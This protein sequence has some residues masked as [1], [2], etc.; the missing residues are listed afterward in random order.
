M[1]RRRLGDSLGSTTVLRPRHSSCL[2]H[3]CCLGDQ[4]PWGQHPSKHELGHPNYRLTPILSPIFQGSSLCLGSTCLC[5]QKPVSIC[6]SFSL[7]Q[8]SGWP[9][10][11]HAAKAN[12]QVPDFPPA[13]VLKVFMW[14][15]DRAQ[16]PVYPRKALHQ[17]NPSHG[18]PVFFE[19]EFLQPRM[20]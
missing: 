11:H 9:P 17:L 1:G 13:W 12:V 15:G 7:K 14:S 18:P 2:S 19:A 4:V 5:P 20:V 3:T 8:V 6:L 16:G 10:T